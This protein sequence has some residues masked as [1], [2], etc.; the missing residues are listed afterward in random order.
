MSAEI[1]TF[2]WQGHET[3]SWT[4]SPDAA[5]EGKPSNS[6]LQLSHREVWEGAGPGR[7]LSLATG[8]CIPKAPR[9]PKRELKIYLQTGVKVFLLLSSPNVLQIIKASL[10]SNFTS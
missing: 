3:L 4:L 8:W 10:D 9:E 2:S 6:V 5:R 7:D 1:F